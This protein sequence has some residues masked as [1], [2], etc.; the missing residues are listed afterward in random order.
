MLAIWVGPR[1]RRLAVE[2]DFQTVGDFLEWRYGER[3][4]LV[5]AVLLWFTT[6]TILAAQL[7]AISSIVNVVAGLPKCVGCLLGGLVMTTYFIAGGLLSSVGVNVVQLTVKFIGFGV[8]LPLALAAVGGL[9][10]LRAAA[11]DARVLEFLSRAARR[12]GSTWRCSRPRLSCRPASFRKSS[13]RAT[14]A[15]CAS[16]SASTRWC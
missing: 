16:A 12:D 5:V 15:P 1:I 14:I 13:A 8:A 3:V 2:H 11:A 10:A 9:D 4:R 7:I 6:L